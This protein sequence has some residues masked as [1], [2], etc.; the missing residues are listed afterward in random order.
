VYLLLTNN[1][2]RTPDKVDGPNPRAKN[3]HGHIVELVPPGSGPD[4]DHAALQFRW[5]ILWWR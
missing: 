2:S 4:A 1:T 5:N 3:K